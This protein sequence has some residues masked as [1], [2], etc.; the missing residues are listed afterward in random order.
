MRRY[1]CG[2]F[3]EAPMR[4]RISHFFAVIGFIVVV[5]ALVVV[6]T[7]LVVR[8]HV[9]KKTVLELNLEEPLVEAVPEDTLAQAF[10]RDRA[11]VRDIVDALERGANDDRVVGLVARFGN[12]SI[13]FAKSQEI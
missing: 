13:G 4:K 1:P 12:T 7:L 6:V 11:N 2:L 5:Y 8:K 9:P 3:L 10:N